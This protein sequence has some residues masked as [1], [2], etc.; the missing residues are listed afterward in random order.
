MGRI[1]R[2]CNNPWQMEM[3]G[4]GIVEKEKRV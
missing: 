2:P 4:K 1:P 3:Q